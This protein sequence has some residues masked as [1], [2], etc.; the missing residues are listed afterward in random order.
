L[1]Y[2][3]RNLKFYPLSIFKA[4]KPKGL[5]HFISHSFH[6]DTCK[7]EKKL[8]TKLDNWEL[9]NLKPTDVLD[10]PQRLTREYGISP[11]FMEKVLA[12]YSIQETGKDVLEREFEMKP[13]Q[14]LLSTTRHYSWPKGAGK[15]WN[16]NLLILC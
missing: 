12:E 13:A 2:E 1:L 15:S 14:Y 7:G 11:T 3:A 9:L 8:F 6:I 16:S 5:L 4:L 10:I